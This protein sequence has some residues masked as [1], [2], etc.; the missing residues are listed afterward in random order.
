MVVEMAAK[1]KTWAEKLD[2][3]KEPEVGVMNRMVGGVPAGGKM[4]IP[5]PRQVDTYIRSIPRGVSKT[6]LEMGNALA[7]EFGADITCPLC[8][9]IFVRIASEAAHEE[10]LAGSPSS[11]VTPFWRIIPPKAPIRK[12]IAFAALVDELRAAEGLPV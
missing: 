6:S 11:D 2:N 10:M 8:C 1:R 3:G 9:G 12:K 7:K 4:L 5:T